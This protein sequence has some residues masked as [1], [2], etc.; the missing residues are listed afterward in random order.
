M[1]ATQYVGQNPGH[2]VPYKSI[3]GFLPLM[4]NNQYVA[5]EANEEIWNK[6]RLRFIFF[7]FM[8]EFLGINMIVFE[9]S[10]SIRFEVHGRVID[11]Q[12][13]LVGWYRVSNYGYISSRWWISMR[14]LVTSIT[15][16]M[17]LSVRPSLCLPKKLA[18][19]CHQ[20]IITWTNKVKWI[21]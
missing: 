15:H 12:D 2:F 4:C 5:L 8:Y 16:S 10:M 1:P 14:R 20:K 19:T 11:T 3:I 7:P 17:G 9:V 13:S 21:E 18:V 6:L